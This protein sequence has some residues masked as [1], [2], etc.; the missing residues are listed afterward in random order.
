MKKTAVEWLYNNLKSHFEH[1]GDLLEI[2]QMSFEQAK[3]MEKQQMKI[4]CIRTEYEDKAWQNLMEK[5]FEQYYN[6][7]FK[8]T[9]Q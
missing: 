7:T 6:E 9:E 2:V 4:A 3:E 1:D 8:N 5:Q